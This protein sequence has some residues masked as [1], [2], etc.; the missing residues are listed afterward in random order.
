MDRSTGGFN[1]LPPE[2]KAGQV[3]NLI[4]GLFA[5]SGG[6]AR[7][8]FAVDRS[9]SMRSNVGGDHTRM[10]V[11]NQHLTKAL[12]AHEGAGN[13]FGITTFTSS[14]ATPLGSQA[15]EATPANI[16]KATSVVAGFTA[17]GSNGGEA[18]CLTTL[19]QMN[20]DVVFFLGDGGW[21]KDKLIAEA[22]KA[23]AKNVKINSV[24]F[25]TTGGGLEEIAEITGGEW[26]Q[27]ND[28]KEFHVDNQ[29]GAGDW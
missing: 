1:K 21:S 3:F 25:Y 2:I 18:A 13:Y 15:L 14:C 11:V 20:L 17:R 7:I 16:A 29:G 22:H 8:G 19:L 10:T 6:S 28:I 12:Q 27:V 23:K 24:A 5:N 4:V 9:G 26:R